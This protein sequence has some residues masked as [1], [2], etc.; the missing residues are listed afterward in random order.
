M[1]THRSGLALGEQP[2]RRL[3]FRTL[4]VVFHRTVYG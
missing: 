4:M 3:H 1:S 2:Y